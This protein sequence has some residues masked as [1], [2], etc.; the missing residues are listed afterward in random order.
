MRRLNPT[1]NVELLSHYL[2]N[3]EDFPNRPIPKAVPLIL[4]EETGEKLYI[5]EKLLMKRT[6]RRKRQWLVKWHG[7]PEHEATWE[8]E[9][10]IKHVS[11]WRQL[12]EEFRLRQREVNPGEMSCPHPLA[13]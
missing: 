11:D 3:R 12:L 4:D 9:A 5:V 7:L 8:S 10:Q 13:C 1:F 6:K 2:T